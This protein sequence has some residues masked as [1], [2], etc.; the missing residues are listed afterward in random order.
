[1]NRRLD[2][3]AL[4]NG[5]LALVLLVAAMACLMLLGGCTVGPHGLEFGWRPRPAVETT[6]KPVTVTTNAP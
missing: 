3:L 4:G 5:V 6:G 1:M 2:Q